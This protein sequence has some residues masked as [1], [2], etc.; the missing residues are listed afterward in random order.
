MSANLCVNIFWKQNDSYTNDPVGVLAGQ[1]G[2]DAWTK[3]QQQ[4]KKKKKK[5]K[6]MRK[7]TVLSWAV[8]STV[9]I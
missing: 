6:L 5:K 7:G 4:Q 2:T 8:R 9:I 3:Q 1:L